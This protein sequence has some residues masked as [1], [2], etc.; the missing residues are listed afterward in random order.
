MQT[1]AGKTGGRQATRRARRGRGSVWPAKDS[2]GRIVRNVWRVRYTWTDADGG[3]HKENRTAYGTKSDAWAAVA[4]MEAAH[5]LGVTGDGRRVTFA[6]FAADWQEAREQS[7]ELSAAA[8][9]ESRRIASRFS[10]YIGKTPVADITPAMIDGMMRKIREDRRRPDGSTLSNNT[11]RKY[12]V[13]LSQI[14]RKAC[15][16]D[17]IARNPCDRVKKPRAQ[18]VH[19]RALSAADARRLSAEVADEL[20]RAA[21]EYDAKER[22]MRRLG[23]D[24][25]RARLYGVGELANLI[26]VQIGLATGARLGEV[27]GMTWAAVDLE[28]RTIRID[29]ARKKAHGGGWETAAPKTAAGRRIVHIDAGTAARL[30]WWKTLQARM[31]RDLGALGSRQRTPPETPVVCNGAGTWSDQDNFSRWW[32]D[33]RDAH[34]F[35][36]LKFHELRHTQ[37]TQLLANGTD[38]ETVRA[39]LGHANAAITMSFYVH[40]VSD[41]DGEAADML[42]ELLGQTG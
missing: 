35:R 24:G 19:R 2:A 9:A 33:W 34:G 39:R 21:R 41:K 29:K 31:L 3:E 5:A 1:T 38:I 6:D 15:D 7:G 30:A 8:C 10:E 36:S 18:E 32:R 13:Y 40:P 28:G 12:H 26:A 27:L 23:K 11:L 22:R 42:G 17:L 16:Y 14:M 4:D 25:P 37:A 20:E